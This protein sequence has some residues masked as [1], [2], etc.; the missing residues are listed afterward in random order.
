MTMTKREAF[1]VLG[2]APGAE[3][4]AATAAFKALALKY[5]PDRN[6]AGAERMKQLTAAYAMVRGGDWTEPGPSTSTPAPDP[7]PPRPAARA[8]RRRRAPRWRWPASWPRVPLPKCL[9]RPVVALAAP[10]AALLVP[11]LVLWL[12]V[13]HARPLTSTLLSLGAAGLPAGRRALRR[14]AGSKAGQRLIAAL[15]LASREH[16]GRWLL[17]ALLHNLIAAG[18]GVVAGPVELV[19]AAR[20]ASA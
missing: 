12:A 19:R 8:A 7:A 2:L 9:P 13:A 16:V 11:S 14:F 15:E 1:A 6:P 4:E 20:A 3:P 5:H 18:V 10:Y 17:L